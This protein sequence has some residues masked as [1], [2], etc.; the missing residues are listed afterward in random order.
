MSDEPRKWTRL[1]VASV[2]LTISLLYPLSF[3]PAVQLGV[4]PYQHGFYKPMWALYDS[5]IFGGIVHT[6]LHFWY[7]LIGPCGLWPVRR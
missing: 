6:Y 7:D 2:L 4:A 5:E 1:W 3:G